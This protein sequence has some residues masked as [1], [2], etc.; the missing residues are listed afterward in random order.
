M[1]VYCPECNE[2]YPNSHH[3][4]DHLTDEH[5]AFS[6]LVEGSPLAGHAAAPRGE[7]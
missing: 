7:R 3:L 5:D 1:S 6:W 2:T 4:V